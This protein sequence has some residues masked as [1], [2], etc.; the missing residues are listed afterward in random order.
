MRRGARG[1]VARLL[2]AL[3]RRKVGQVVQDGA[4]LCGERPLAAAPA[5]KQPD[6]RFLT[7]H[8]SI[9]KLAFL[10]LEHVN[11]YSINHCPDN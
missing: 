5:C 6:W 3:C 10:R 9:I 1:Q 2:E 4:Q 7:R 8:D 11:L